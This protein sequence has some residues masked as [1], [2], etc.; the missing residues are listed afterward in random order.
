MLVA[1]NSSL[2]E[3]NV[4]SKIMP[5]IRNLGASEVMDLNNLL[6]VLC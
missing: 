2:N 4:H 1:T 3:Y 5:G 6:A